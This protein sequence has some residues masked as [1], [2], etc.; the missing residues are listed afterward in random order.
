MALS[1]QQLVGNWVTEGTQNG[2]SYPQSGAWKGNLVLRTN[3]TTSMKF[4]SGNVAPPRNGDWSLNG[5][6][7]S[8][9]DAQGSTWTAT[10]NSTTQPSAMSGNYSAGPAGAQGGS[11][12]ARKL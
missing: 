8:I 1:T 12:S 10:I 4:T 11:W 3:M 5:T 9:I 2:W 7:M 6:T